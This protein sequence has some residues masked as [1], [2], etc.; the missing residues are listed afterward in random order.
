VPLSFPAVRLAN[1]VLVPLE[2]FRECM[3]VT[4]YSYWVLLSVLNG[5]PSYSK[6]DAVVASC[7]D[8]LV[9]VV[10]IV[11]TGKASRDERHHLPSYDPGSKPDRR[12]LLCYPH[13]ASFIS[14]HDNDLLSCDSVQLTG[15]RWPRRCSMPGMYC[16][17]R[18]PEYRYR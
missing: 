13:S 1:L 17:A 11:A 10:A 3:H 14:N 16:C 5:S 6:V 7:C 15:A 8:F 4:G 12:S 9:G 18:T 2:A